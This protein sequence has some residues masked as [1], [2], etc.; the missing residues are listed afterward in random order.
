MENTHREIEF[1]LGSS[2]ESAIKELQKYKEKNELVFGVFNNQ[3]L[4]SDTDDIDSAYLKITG[5]TKT[6]CDEEERIRNE[7]YLEEKRIH[8]EN[9]PKLT[10]YWIVKGRGALDRKYRSKWN[11]CVPIRLRDIYRGYELKSTLEIV[12]FLK[13]RYDISIPKN[14]IE[15]QGHSGMSFG[16]VCAIIKAFSDRG[17]DFVDYVNK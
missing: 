9:L 1:S 14:I 8:E 15:E 12:R 3:K 11:K 16:L 5:R 13:P 4:F 7:K 10:K 6:E 17:E 2:I